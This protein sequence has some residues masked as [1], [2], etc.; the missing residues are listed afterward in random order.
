MY[1]KEAAV[2]LQ[3][4][5]QDIV[6]GYAMIEQCS[7]DLKTLRANVDDYAQRIFLHSC[8]LA[9]HSGIAVTMPRITQIQRH[10]SNAES[11]S[12][13]EYFKRSVVIPFLDHLI[14]D[15]SSRFDKHAKQVASL[16]GLLPTKITSASSMQDIEQAVAFYSSDLPNAAIV[17][18]EFHVWKTRW[19]SVL[20][21]DRPQTITACMKNCSSQ[22]FSNIFTLLKLFA[23][24]PLSSCSCERSA[25]TLR[26]LNN[27]MR[28]TQTEDRL[29]GLALVHAHYHTAI[30]VDSVCKLF[31]EKQPRRIEAAS[32][33]FE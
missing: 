24:L 19:L 27:Y 30:D 28:C 8:R 33:L 18:E 14:S 26:R 23:T 25:S 4:E 11:D 20:P 9:E 1:L 2:R 5:N 13:E 6:S 16:Q 17:D 22:T 15:L 31:L 29:T 21:Q 10:R 12:V 3:G 32:L 7:T